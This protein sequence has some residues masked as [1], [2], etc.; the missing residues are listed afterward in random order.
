MTREEVIRMTNEVFTESFE[1]EA[2]RLI[3]EAH[4]FNDLGLDSL[5]IVDLVVALQKKFSV[6]IRNDERVR[7]IRTL[8]DI[9]D[10][11][12]TLGKEGAQA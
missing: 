2:E 5:D 12:I 6:S 4:I 9:Y 7:S 10:F 8:G 11:I 1:I 3:P